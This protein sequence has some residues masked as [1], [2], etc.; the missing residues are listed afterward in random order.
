MDV[1]SDS[2][3]VFVFFLLGTKIRFEPLCFAGFVWPKS[4]MG[5]GL[6]RIKFLQCNNTKR[7]CSEIPWRY[8][9]INAIS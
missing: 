4:R 2:L 6:G 8:P 1:V 3:G 9:Y 7:R 5:H